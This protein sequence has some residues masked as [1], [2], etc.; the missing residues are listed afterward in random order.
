MSREREKREKEG[1]ANRTKSTMQYVAFAPMS[2]RCSTEQ[3]ARASSMLIAVLN[4]SPYERGSNVHHRARSY[5]LESISENENGNYRRG[6]VYI[7]AKCKFDR[8]LD[9][10]AAIMMPDLRE[11]RRVLRSRHSSTRRSRAE[12]DIVCQLRRRIHSEYYRRSALFQARQP[13][14]SR[15]RVEISRLR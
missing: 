14:T 3:L 1:G 12:R 6:E 5:N 8:A 7:C 10:E 9:I 15:A 4:Q 11:K 13:T 2:S